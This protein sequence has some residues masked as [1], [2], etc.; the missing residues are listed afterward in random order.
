MPQVEGEALRE[1]LVEHDTQGIDVA[2]LIN[3]S[4]IT[5]HLLGTHVGDGSHQ[6][7]RA[8]LKRGEPGVRVR[9]ARDAEVEYLRLASNGK[10]CTLAGRRRRRLIYH[11][12]ILRFQVAVNDTLLV[13]VVYGIADACH[14][15]EAYLD[16]E[17]VLFRVLPEFLSLDVLHG[18]V[19][20]AGLAGIDL[21]RI[22]DL[23]YAGMPEPAQ[24][25]GLEAEPFQQALGQQTGA[26]HLE[27]HAAL[28]MVLL[29]Q[30][31]RAHAAFA[32]LFENAVGAD[33]LFQGG[34]PPLRGGRA[35]AGDPQRSGQDLLPLADVLLREEAPVFLIA[36]QQTFH[37]MTQLLI[38]PAGAIEKR[39]AI[40]ALEIGR[41]EEDFHDPLITLVAHDRL[42][43]LSSHLRKAR[44]VRHS[45]WTVLGE[46]SRTWATSDSLRPARNRISTM[47][48]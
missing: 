36:C 12:D 47:R 22:V 27:R 16:A 17:V 30:E 42:S 25:L 41:L 24:H 45:R 44:A 32:D 3:L 28:G 23:R 15:L 11:E 14:E 5:G 39:S 26:D 38:A 43:P 6:L 10:G 1:Q 34:R 8:G 9:G 48:H 35:V 4:R 46:S 33:P 2:A 20:Q 37:V 21:A 31:D 19:G 18:E 29:G 7:S 13:G 40:G